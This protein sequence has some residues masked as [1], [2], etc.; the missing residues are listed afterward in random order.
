MHINLLKKYLVVLLCLP[1]LYVCFF[2]ADAAASAAADTSLTVR[3][4]IYENNPKIFTDSTGNAAGFWPDII[5]SIAAEE[6]WE[7]RWVHGAW[8]ES[9]ERLKNNEIDIMPDVAYTEE[10]NNIYAFSSETVYTSWTQ[11]YTREGASIQ[12]IIDLEGR[13]IAVLKGS[14]NV[15][16]P[17]GIKQL[18]KAFNISCTFV[19][20]DSYNSV[21]EYVKN[22][23]AD[24]G[25]TSKDFGYRY[26]KEFNLVDTAII[27]QPSSLFF[28]FP[29]NSSLTPV[30]IERIDAH[31]RDMKADNDSIYYQS[32]RKWFAQEPFEK[33]IVPAWLIWLLAG[34]AG[35][36]LV[37]AVFGFI[38]RSQVKTRTSELTTEIIKRKQ[39]ETE[40]KQYEAQ[41]EGLVKQRT[42]ELEEAN[43][44]KSQFLANMSH[45]L[46]TPL[47]SIIGYTKLMLD[48]LEGSV[49][50]E[51]KEDLQTVY[52]NSKHLLSLINDLLD[53][54]KIEAGK[55]EI[56]KENFTVNDFLSKIIPGM[57]KLAKD[58]GLE[59]SYSVSPGI[60]KIYADKNKTKQVLFNLLGNAVKFTQ[61][62]GVHLDINEK[63][64]EIIFSV[65]D[66]GIGIA[67]ED[68]GAL[69]A[70]Y[71]QV[72]PA[73]LDGSEGTG[74]GLVISKQFVEKQGGRIWVE[75]ELGKGSSFIFTLPKQ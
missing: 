11:V 53:L 21:F 65:R 66:T 31:I 40:L 30:L 26:Q 75:S 59:L 36:V 64:S 43:L 68:I 24:A 56:I 16:G 14:V 58:K 69:F 19:E 13:K 22:G 7:I 41:L 15:E 8:A 6:G 48:G 25:V 52:D 1:C 20:T 17:D 12:S 60:E 57:E 18:A 51:Q 3:V 4:G 74:L 10:R 42:A 38:L 34:I 49:T 67:K 55:F 2:G 37:L 23:I 29:R 63:D 33:S 5:N 72:G 54:S 46:R 47:N 45:E 44:H 9:L 70:S 35:L 28:A 71:K 27:F 50:S 73:R 39:A 61:K 62:G 32:L